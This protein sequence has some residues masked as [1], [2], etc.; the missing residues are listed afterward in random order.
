[1]NAASEQ[2]L[3]ALPWA[4]LRGLGAALDAPLAAVLAG[5]PAERVV[6]RVLRA[7]RHLEADQRRAVKEAIY[8]VAVW[9]RRL[10]W[11]AQG[12]SPA[13]VPGAGGEAGG[14]PRL[15]LAALLRDLGGVPEAEAL[16]GLAA[17]TLPPPRA[18]PD[19]AAVRFS[20]PDWLWQTLVR[21]VGP[22]APRLADAL[23]LPGPLCLR[24]NRLR[25]T[26]GAL[27]ARL[28]AEGVAT[29]PGALVPSALR[30][31]SAR[32]NVYGLAAWQEGLFE[33][34]DEA[35]QL[36]GAAVAASPGETILDLC[37]G[38]GGKT[39]LLAAAVG[40]SGAVHACDVDGERLARLAGRARRAG[41]GSIVRIGGGAPP[42][43]L[44]ADAVLVD[45][46]CSELGALRR[47]PDRRFRLD[48][49]ELA[50]LPLLQRTLLDRAATHVRPGGRLVYATCTFRSEEDEAVADAFERDHP[51]FGR[52]AEWRTWPHRDG[53]DAFYVARW[54]RR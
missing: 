45:A 4:A 1:M 29:E 43:A 3:R 23:D 48:P 20:F 17:G 40:A 8:G 36:A 22:E 27:A 34:Q 39:L 16:V 6:D 52:E 44:R 41:A 26:P 46:P 24:P 25:T 21:E 18:A 37:A 31:A 2:R 53:A 13:P 15:L 54:R 28:A 11:H 32:V 9:R 49:A 19:D 47:G 12:S 7:H 33:V 10:A 14:S 30:V 35:S 38:A 42:A 50:R 5:E 51:A